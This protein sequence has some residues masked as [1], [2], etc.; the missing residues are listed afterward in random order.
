MRIA[1]CQPKDISDSRLLASESGIKRAGVTK[2]ISVGGDPAGPPKLG[3]FVQKIEGPEIRLWN[4]S[5]V[6]YSSSGAIMAVYA[7]FPRSRSSIRMAG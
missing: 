6:N 7:A 4:A 3:N 1:H 2:L 5:G